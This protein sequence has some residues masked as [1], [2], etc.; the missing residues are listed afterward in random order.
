[1]LEVEEEEELEMLEVEL[2]ITDVEK[3]EM[4]LKITDVEEEEERG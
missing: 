1:M 3:E 4:E 2:G